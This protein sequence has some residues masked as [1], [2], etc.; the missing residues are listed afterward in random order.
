MIEALTLF[1][2][3]GSADSRA[4]EPRVVARIGSQVV[5]Y[6][7]IACVPAIEA[8]LPEASDESIER[9]CDRVEQRRLNQILS[10]AVVVKAVQQLNI[11][12]STSAADAFLRANGWSDKKFEAI[13]QS[14]YDV[15]RAVLKVFDGNKLHDV[16]TRDLSDAA[17]RGMTELQ[18]A[19]IVKSFSSRE[20]ILQAI[21]RNSG[22]AMR[23]DAERSMRTH[24]RAE[25]LSK[26]I[27]T[28]ATHPQDDMGTIA[29]RFWSE[30]LGQ[31]QVTIVDPK[32]RLPTFVEGL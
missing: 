9:V 5:R 18:F 21:E 11:D 10:E 23:K 12:V 14:T 15:A 27:Q 16:F 25:A 29:S 6:A 24:L 26:Y 32:Y 3:V 13:A 22:V 1:L 2:L 19:A 8:A 31:Y 7:D 30:L 4:A 28:T 20:A 17:E